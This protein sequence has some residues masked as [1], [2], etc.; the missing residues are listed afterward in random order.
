MRWSIVLVVLALT[1]GACGGPSEAAIQATVGAA[2]QATTQAGQIATSVQ[3]TQE[4]GACEKPALSVYADAAEKRVQV[5]EQQS[6]L[7]S[8]TPRIA[9][10]AFAATTGNPNRDG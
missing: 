2:V 8:S 4:A 5:F 1:L 7:A 9:R 10:G 6:S 3:A